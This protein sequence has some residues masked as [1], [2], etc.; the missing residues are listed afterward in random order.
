MATVRLGPLPVEEAA[1]CLSY[2]LLEI[3]AVLFSKELTSL[4]TRC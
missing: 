4:S 1:H 3:K 2:L